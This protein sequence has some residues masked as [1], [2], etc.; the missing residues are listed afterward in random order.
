[1]TPFQDRTERLVQRV[2]STLGKLPGDPSPRYVHRLRTAIRRI[3]SLVDYA[4]P[5]LGRKQ[6]KALREMAALRRRA[7]KVR[8]LDVQTMLLNDIANGSTIKDRRDVSDALK[9]KRDKQAARLV[10][11]TER[12]VDAKFLCQLERVAAKAAE[13]AVSHAVKDP[14]AEAVNRLAEAEAEYMP[15]A[16]H[17]PAN[18]HQVRIRMKKIRYVAELAEETPDRQ[19]FVERLQSAQDTLGAWHDWQ[20]MARTAEKQFRQRANCPLLVEIRA[21]L[22]ARQTTAAAAVRQLF[23]RPA[24]LPARKHPPSIGPARELARRAG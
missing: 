9:Q 21:L 1:M 18:L 24:E 4:R 3:E 20:E 17:Q 15:R 19:L 5:D 16:D 12:I 6:Q 2:A 10:S 22:A 14:L 13:A 8:D 11:A 23:A 7:G